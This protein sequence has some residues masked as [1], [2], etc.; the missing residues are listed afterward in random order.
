L[1]AESNSV[2]WLAVVVSSESEELLLQRAASGGAGG[3]W[4]ITETRN[5]RPAIIVFVENRDGFSAMRDCI[6]AMAQLPNAR[7]TILTPET[8]AGR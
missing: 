2:E 7:I 3:P 5:G 4:G 8:D 6:G 1:P